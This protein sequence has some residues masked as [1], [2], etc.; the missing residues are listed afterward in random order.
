MNSQSFYLCSASW[1]FG[2]AERLERLS[3]S[4]V[5]GFS[6]DPYVVSEVLTNDE[7]L[8]ALEPGWVLGVSPWQ[9]VKLG[10]E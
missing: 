2:G 5:K 1:I 8:L 7:G 6:Y 9:N 3:G 4:T 10:C